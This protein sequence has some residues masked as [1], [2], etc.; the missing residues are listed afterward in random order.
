MVCIQLGQARPP[1]CCFDR[2]D[3]GFHEQNYT[4]GFEIRWASLSLGWLGC[5]LCWVA[6]SLSS[7]LVIHTVQECRPFVYSGERHT[8]CCLFDGQQNKY[9]HISSLYYH[10]K[11]FTE[12]IWQFD[13]N[14]FVFAEVNE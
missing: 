9:F 10:C 2:I 7:L 3:T 13:L 5:S 12:F 8:T 4:E 11:V 6:L 14:L 1:T